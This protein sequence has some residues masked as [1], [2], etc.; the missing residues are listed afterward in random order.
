MKIIQPERRL[1][2]FWGAVDKKMIRSFV[3]YLKGKE[4]LDIGCGNG[5]TTDYINKNT[6]FSCTGIDDDTE[7][8]TNAK[9]LFPRNNFVLGKGERLPFDDGSFDTIIL[10]D[11]IHHIWE[12]GD[13]EKAAAEIARVAKPDARLIIYDPNVNFVLRTLRRMSGHKDA[14]CTFQ[15]AVELLPRLG[16]KMTK[17]QFNTLFSLPLSGGY[18]WY[19][20]VPNINWLYNF[21]LFSERVGEK[22]INGLGLGRSLCMRYL[23]IAERTNQNQI[24]PTNEK[25]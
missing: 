6:D 15:T 3:P 23:I 22:I 19:N 11:T 17:K 18:V 4:I 5:S 10:R 25:S 13:F 9:R 2:L 21:V 7:A 14:S 16:F 24:N 1:K 12:E 20:F 8:I